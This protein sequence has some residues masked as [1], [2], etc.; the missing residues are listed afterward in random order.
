ME[1]LIITCAPTG[2]LTVPTQTDYLPITPEQIAE[3]S[4]RAAEA[5]CSVVHIHAREPANGK[6]TSDIGIFKDIITRIKTRSNVVVGITTGGGGGMTPEERIQVVPNLKPELASLNMGPVCLSLKG[7]MKRIKD[8]DYKFDWEKPYL[9]LLG[10]VIQHNTFK[11]IELFLRT[12]I[13][14]DTKPECECYDISHV[15]NAA[16]FYK[17]GLFKTPVWL[18]FVTGGSGSIGSSPEDVLHLKHTADKLLGPDN[19][20][21]SIIGAGTAFINTAPLAIQLGGHVR[22]GMEDNI[23]VKKGVLARSNV[24]LVEK[25][26]RM[27]KEAGR[28]IA[29]PDEVRQ[30][31]G[32]KGKDKVNY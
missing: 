9:D 18:Q 24:E 3:E 19:Y 4:V 5:G 2:S 15:Y 23:F 22:V 20:R 8:S 21:W 29:S 17:E 31:L 11:S 16:S 30:M 7:V 1:K 28:E 13:A 6:P 32:L 27:A 14:N 25:V 26:V 10:G 12:M